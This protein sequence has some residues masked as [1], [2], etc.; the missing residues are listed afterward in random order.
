LDDAFTLAQ[1]GQLDYETAL[2]LTRYLD[3]ETEFLPWAM[4]LG[5]VGVI[6]AYFDD[7][8]EADAFKV[9]A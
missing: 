2:S 1:A 5:G 3:K 7:E 9:Y 6:Q 4:A 8:P